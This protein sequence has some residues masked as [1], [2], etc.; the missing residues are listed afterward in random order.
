MRHLPAPVRG[1]VLNHLVFE[2][3]LSATT[4]DRTGRASLGYIRTVFHVKDRV[5]SSA[6]MMNKLTL[7]EGMHIHSKDGLVW[8]RVGWALQAMRHLRDVVVRFIE[9]PRDE[10]SWRRSCATLALS[11][12]LGRL[13]LLRPAGPRRPLLALITCDEFKSLLRRLRP[14]CAL[15]TALLWEPYFPVSLIAEIVRRGADLSAAIPSISFTSSSCPLGMACAGA[16]LEVVQLL[17]DNGATSHYRVGSG[18]RDV[19]LKAA[20]AG[21]LDLLRLLYDSG[22]ISTYRS[23]GGYNLLLVLVIPYAISSFTDLELDAATTLSM[24]KLICAR[25]PLLSTQTSAEGRTPLM[26][27]VECFSSRRDSFRPK[28]TPSDRLALFKSLSKCMVRCEA[29]I[30]LRASE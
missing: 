30:R 12:E 27:L 2:D 18:R 25:Q 5:L 26:L 16:R 22:H 15:V 10:I 13:R 1:L 19:F 3:V 24:V 6:V 28:D 11:P 7:C 20:N 29:K 9:A 8:E 14:D 23:L 17:L 4:T 21:S